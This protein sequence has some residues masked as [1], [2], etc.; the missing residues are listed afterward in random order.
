M[1]GRATKE[2]KRERNFPI[3]RVGGSKRR[4]FPIKEWEEAEAQKERK[5]PIKDWKKREE[6][7]RKGSYPEIGTMAV[8][9]I[10]VVV[11]ALVVVEF[12]VLV[13]VNEEEGTS[14]KSNPSL[15]E[16]IN[17]NVGGKLF[18][19][20]LS[21]LHSND[22]NSLLFSLSNRRLAD[23]S[24]IFIDRD[25]EILSILLS[26]LRT[27]HL[28][29]VVHHFSKH[30]LGD[31]ALFYGIDAHLCAAAATPP[32]SDIDVA[33][34]ASLR[35]PPSASPPLLS[36]PPPALSRSPTVAKSP[37]PRF[38]EVVWEMNEPGGSGQSS[39]FGDSFVD[40]EGLLLFMLCSK[41]GDLAM[42]D[43]RFLKDD[44]WVYLK[45]KNPSLV[46]YGE[47]RNI[48]VHC[49]R[50]QVFVAKEGA[51][52]VWSSVEQRENSG[53]GAE[54][55]YRRDFMDKR[56]DSERGVIKKIEGGGYRLFVSREDVEGIEVWERLAN[57]VR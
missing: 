54:G 42:A 37:D 22:P 18:E 31:E 35:P 39:R 25:L 9:L 21:M 50:G 7:C 20:M 29:S 47:V 2:N 14:T 23:P 16:R 10:Q 46:S 17:L 5:F 53:S 8:F 19:T 4:K 49:Y 26:L 43:M 27:S 12:H 36:L 15:R 56:E 30:E 13:A 51:L 6:I 1:F 44:P 41:S 55:F 33:L 34:F 32:F 40:V 38:G 52:E 28:P 48:V 3:K 45:E 24:P 11:L 57:L